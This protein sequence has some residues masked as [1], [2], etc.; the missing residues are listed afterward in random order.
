MLYLQ[1]RDEAKIIGKHLP[2][3]FSTSQT[4]E[5]QD[6]KTRTGVNCRKFAG[7][8]RS[9]TDRVRGAT[10]RAAGRLGKQQHVDTGWLYECTG[11]TQLFGFDGGTRRQQFGK[12]CE[13]HDHERR[14]VAPRGCEKE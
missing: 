10:Q 9:R 4:K 6:E 5:T 7:V 13:R 8:E 11:D 1:R 12:P 3:R 14:A 2:S